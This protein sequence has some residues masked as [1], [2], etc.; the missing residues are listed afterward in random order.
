MTT[1]E[2]TDMATKTT[3]TRVRTILPEGKVTLTYS[4]GDPIELEV[5]ADSS[6]LVTDEQRTR[7]ERTGYVLPDLEPTDTP[8]AG[9]GAPSGS[10][11]DTT[12]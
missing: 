7:L 10:E 1:K 2:S 9:S 3:R 5:D 12:E 4:T 11:P 6:A 8:P